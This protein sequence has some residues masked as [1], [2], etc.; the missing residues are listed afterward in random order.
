VQVLQKAGKNLT[1]EKLIEAVQSG[2]FRNAAAGPYRYSKSD[3]SGI[4]GMQMGKISGGA[5]AAFGPVL[6]TDEADGAVKEYTEQP[7]TPPGNGI[8]QA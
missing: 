7:A 8:P 6:E 5:Q 2:G 1:R 3:H 4:G